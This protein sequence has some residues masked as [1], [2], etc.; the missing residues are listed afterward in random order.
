MAMEHSGNPRVFFDIKIG[1][2][3]G[4]ALMVYK[5]TNHRKHNLKLLA[6]LMMELLKNTDIFRFG[7]HVFRPQIRYFVDL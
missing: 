1:N 2:D 6:K 4:N 5:D 3:D 7:P